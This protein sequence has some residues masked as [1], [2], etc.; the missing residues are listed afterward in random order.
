MTYYERRRKEPPCEDCENEPVPLLAANEP[1]WR[2]W[3]LV[4][5]QWRVGWSLVGL[6]YPAVFAVAE[7]HGMGMS[8]E[9][10]RGL[11]TLEYDT[12]EEQREEWEKRK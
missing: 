3:L 4:Q 2:L 11:Q 5:T 6:D 12:L 10:F 9:L 1:V 7:L 8:P